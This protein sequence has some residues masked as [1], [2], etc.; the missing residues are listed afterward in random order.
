MDLIFQTCKFFLLPSYNLSQKFNSP[1]GLSLKFRLFQLFPFTFCFR[2]ITDADAIQ[3]LADAAAHL[4]IFFPFSLHCLP[5]P[6][7]NILI[8][9]CMEDLAE[10]LPSLCSSG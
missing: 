9:P 5:Q 6:V 2:V 1:N 10:D 7:L 4:I 3:I 8:D